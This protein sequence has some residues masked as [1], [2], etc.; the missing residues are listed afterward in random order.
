[1][2]L[3]LCFFNC[4]FLLFQEAVE[5]GK[6]DELRLNKARKLVLLVDLDETLLHTTN[7]NVPAN[8]QVC[9]QLMICLQ[10]VVWPFV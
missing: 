9:V 4:I 2:F 5:L 1:M 6:E 7:D 3:V 10:T 8:L